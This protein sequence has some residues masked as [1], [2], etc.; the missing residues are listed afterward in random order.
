LRISRSFL[1]GSKIFLLLVSALLGQNQ[2]KT[3]GFVHDGPWERNQQIRKQIESEIR[4][5]LGSRSVQFPE[6]KRKSG[7]WTR[8]S[9]ARALDSLLSDPEVD[10]V[11][12]LGLLSSH[13]A[14]SRKTLN[15]PVIASRVVA[16]PL[17][18]IPIQESFGGRVSGIRNLCYLTLG[19]LDI[20]PSIREFQR[21]LP[22]SRAAFLV[23]GAFKDLVPN[24]DSILSR[25][26]KESGISEPRIISVGNSVSQALSQIPRGTQAVI[27]TLL[28]QL[29]PEDFSLL[30]LSLRNRKMPTFS[31][32]GNIFAQFGAL[33]GLGPNDAINDFARQI[34]INTKRIFEGEEPSQLPVDLEADFRLAINVET[35]TALG[36]GLT[37]DLQD[38]LLIFDTMNPGATSP[39]MTGLTKNP[40]P[41][42]STTTS[43]RQL[44][45]KELKREQARIGSEIRRRIFNLAEFSAFDAISPKILG[46]SG[47]TLLGYAYKED[48]KSEIE[49][50]VRSIR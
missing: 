13:E 20:S 5:A 7:V 48:L 45:P 17:L 37:D 27:V 23:S 11:I 6:E 1:I 19:G 15:K 3:I 32:G 34:G 41:V 12:T 49:R 24:L 33:A 26:L 29:D 2:T 36:I 47:I 44:S 22:F 16:S 40:V 18:G 42:F 38:S 31:I 43:K 4:S 50:V 10:L 46:N 35:A 39:S 30:L 21:L 9:V 25:E 8:R 28:P 14:V